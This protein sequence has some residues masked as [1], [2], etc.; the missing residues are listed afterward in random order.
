MFNTKSCVDIDLFAFSTITY[1]LK[2]ILKILYFI[3]SIRK[4]FYCYWVLLINIIRLLIT[5]ITS[6]KLLK[7]VNWY[8]NLAV[9]IHSYTYISWMHL[10]VQFLI[11]EQPYIT[12]LSY[13]HVVHI[14]IFTSRYESTILSLRIQSI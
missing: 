13:I 5:C 7:Y 4:F 11:S 8:L 10:P 6:P 3:C 12:H 2:M 9:L 1:L 14:Y